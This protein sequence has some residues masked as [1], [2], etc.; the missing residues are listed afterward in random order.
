M[1]VGEVTG[2]G[3]VQRTLSSSSLL[4]ADM[5]CKGPMA[6][7]LTVR[8]NVPEVAGSSIR[9][10]SSETY[11]GGAALY[12]EGDLSDSDDG[13]VEKRERDTLE[14]WCDS[15]FRNGYGGFP[16]DTK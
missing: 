13:S 6:D 7:I 12:Y 2:L 9:R 1:M 16:P 3:H 15:A 14:D 8:H 5:V 11:G 10:S 4:E